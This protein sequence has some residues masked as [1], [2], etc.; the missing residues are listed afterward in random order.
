MTSDRASLAIAITFLMV[1][2]PLAAAGVSSWSGPSVV[3]SDG[4]PT[5]VDGFSVPSNSTIM[6]GWIHVSN[7][8]LS[9]SSDSGIVWDEDDFPSGNLA[10]MEI[11]DDG[12]MI[13]KDDGSRSNVSSFDVG[14]IEVTLNSDYTYSPGWR[15]VFVK[16]PGTNLSSC[17]GSDGTF[18]SHGVDDDFDQTLDEDEIE[19]TMYFC[20]TFANQDVVTY[21]SIDDPGENYA[22]GNLSA[23]GGGGSGF[24]GSYTISS[25]IQSITINSGGSNYD[26]SDQ[27]TIQCQ[28]DGIGAE[29]SIGSVNGTGAIQ[30]ITIDESGSGYQSNDFIA[31]SVANGSGASLSANLFSTGI[32]HSTTIS[33][34]GSNYTSAPSIVISDSGGSSGSISATLGDYYDY[35]VDTSTE[36]PGENCDRGGFKIESG[37]DIN[38]NRNL[39][40]TEI[41]Q[42]SFICH[43][44]KL[45]QAT[46]F[47]D[48]GGTVYADEQTLSHGVVPSEA[49]QGIV[50]A[51]TLP[52]HPVPAGTFGHLLIPEMDVPEGD[53]ISSY[54]LT[55]DHWYHLDS[56]STGE[57]DGTWVEYRLKTDGNWENWTYMEP[58]GGYPSTISPEAPTPNG[59]NSSPVPV[60]AS[61]SHSGWVS[62]N[63]SLSNL[64]GI[65]ESQKIQFRFLIW[66]HPNASVERPGWFIDNI[67]VTNYGLDMDIW[68]HGCYTTT[69]NSCTYSANAYGVLERNIDLS[70]TN[71]TSRIEMNLEWDLEGAAN[72]NA[73]VEISLNGNTWAD[74]SSSTSSTSSDCS[75]RTGPIPG[76][77]YIADNG[78]TYY[79]STLRDFRKVS[80][81]IPTG[82]QDKA[83]VYL[84]I[85]V[86]TSANTNFGGNSPS[87]SM[88]GIGVDYIRVLD[89]SDAILFVDDFNSSNT[90]S[91]YG[92]S[93]SPDDWAYR[94]ITMGDQSDSMGFEDSTASAPTVTDAEGWSRSQSG[95]CSSDRCKFTLNKVSSSSGPPDVSSFPYAYGVGFS[96]VYENGINE[97]RLISPTYE[98]PLNG[99]SFLTF[100]HW[101]CSEAGYDGGAVFIKVNGG[102]WQHF[103]PG[104]Y[105]STAYPSLSHNLAGQAI[106]GMDHCTGSSWTGWSST[107]G[108]TNLEANLNPYKGD[109]VKF[110]FAFASDTSLQYAGWFIDN[111]GV[112][113]SNFG[114]PGHWTSPAFSMDQDKRFNHGFVDIEGNLHEDGWLTGSILE[115][116]TGD[117][118]PGFSNISFP[119]SLAGIDADRYP[120][121]RLKVHAG[122]DDPEQS[123]SIERIHIGGKRI[124]N[125]DSG[126]NGWDFS[127]GVEVVNGLLNATAVTGTITSD[128]VF[129]TRPIK[130]VTIQGNLSSSVSVTVYDVWGNSL[131]TKSKGGTIHFPSQ[132]IGYSLS[133][134]LPTNGWIDVIRV[135]PTFSNPSLGSSIDVLDDGTDEW[136]FPISDSS[137]S[138]FG[139]LGWQ[140]LITSSGTSSR[141]ESLILDGSNPQSVTILVPESAAV[142]SGVISITP[143]AGGFSAPVSVSVAGSSVSG[144]SGSNPFT[145]P[146]SIAQV[147]AIGQLS[148]SLTDSGSGRHWVEVPLSI[149]SS[150]PQTVHISSIGIGYLF[151]ENVSG[152]GPSIANYLDSIPPQE[153]SEESEIPVSVTSEYGSIAI[154]GSVIF[155]YMFVNRDFSVPKTL[156]PDGDP[157][158]IVTRHNHLFNNSDISDIT[159]IGTA[160]DGNVI[161]FKVENSDDGAWGAGPQPVTFSQTSGRSLSP[162]SLSTSFVTEEIN[163]D[164]KNDLAVHWI[165]TVDW[166][167]ND[168]DNI[169]WVAAANDESGETIWPAT[170]QSGFGANAVE[171]DLQID[172]FEIKD[173]NGR[174]ISNTY[175]TL[176]YP[177]HILDGGDL[178]VSGTVRF[179]DSEGVRPSPSDFSVGLDLS[180]TVIELQ[181]DEGGS[182]HGTVPAPSGVSQ[183]TLTPVMTRVGPTSSTTGA[184][185]ATGTTTIVEILVDQNPPVAGPIEVQTPVGL[186]SVDGMV[187]PPTSS[188]SP[189]V[190]IS[191]GEA[192][193]ESLT[194]RYWREGIDDSDADGIADEEEYQAQTSQLSQGLTGEQQV[195]FMGIDVSDLNNEMIHLYLE[196]TDW[197]GL[198]YQEGGTGGSPGSTNSWASVVIADDVMVE[199]AGVGLGTGSEGATFSLDRQTQDSIDYFLIPGVEHTFRVR[200]DEPNGFRTI[201][202]ISVFLCGYSSDFGVIHYDPFSGSA[203]SPEGSMV[204]PLSTSTEQITESVT[205][206]SVRFSISWDMPFTEDD[207]PCKPRVLVEDGL[208]QIESQV[209]SSL[210]WSLDNRI[211]A[212]PK[213][214]ED[215]TEPIVPSL[216]LELFLGQ[217]DT[218]RLSG[219]IYHEGSGARMVGAEEGLTVQLSLSY[220]SGTYEST[221]GV[222]QDGNFSVEMTLPNFQPLTPTTLITTS[223]LNT[224]GQSYSVEYSEAKATV[225]TK[226]PSV[227]FDVNEYPDSSLTIIETNSMDEVTV[228]LTILE[229]I[230]M[231]YG[232]LQVSWQFLRNGEPVVGT[233]SSGEIPWISS[234]DGKHV[235]QGELDFT[236]ELQ[237]NILDGD[238]VAFWVS[239]TDKAGNTVSG[240]GGPETPRWTSLRIVE[241]EG[242]YTREVV[243]PTRNPIVGETIKVITYWENPGKNPGT[244]SVG[245]YE[246]KVDGTWVPSISTLLDGPVELYLPPG[247]S[248]IKA[249]FEYQTWQEGQPLLIL[250]VDKDFNNSNYGNIEISDIEVTKATNSDNSGGVTLWVIGSLV[251][252][253]SLMGGAFYVLRRG[254]GGEDYFY[255]DYEEEGDEEHPGWLWDSESGEWVP[256]PDFQG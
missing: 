208:D 252:V 71:S 58:Q 113:I 78:Q 68:H 105:S 213:F 124:L 221:A 57:G 151:F 84:R 182:F 74:I 66:T 110:K 40:S 6:D 144:G 153:L 64:E 245:M 111:A 135:V 179:Q 194:L 172:S 72:D 198:S 2:A 39:E 147:S 103:D 59:A 195:Q 222:F 241:F 43:S 112:K 15:R 7:S 86:D 156:Y 210:S 231:S 161:G 54:H 154:D 200:L 48:L 93:S 223:I 106:F 246:Q 126:G 192:R 205:E 61:T 225:D 127:A 173:S 239:S 163:S 217:G 136:S 51:G 250:V 53:Y 170:S 152:L 190:T 38:K 242:Q 236:P 34:G 31:V 88:E 206:L 30:S 254:G 186:Q 251:V 224:P 42:T 189:Y 44:H 83:N 141:S 158:E 129:S 109:S 115:A 218:F 98:I 207:N 191:E 97:A 233:E 116:G 181:T 142:T 220:G 62:S 60:F 12:E 131:G 240:L 117:P 247:S 196:G 90:M 8:P 67:E 143:D 202:N 253:I 21:L 24:S 96:G 69:S 238:K 150:S 134:T 184:E 174:L 10:G 125:A 100:D 188:F 183:M 33:E 169:F 104:W 249:E 22:V 176:F 244:I 255:D 130:S 23:T 133:V 45:W 20:E 230:G 46:T 248:S 18:I 165:F 121:V 52:G 146:L 140:S 3:N 203:S 199:F 92:M 76:N 211:I 77:G 27:I 185:D 49:S 70:G 177:F 82:F 187:V 167:W 193:G 120:N 215:L 65:E 201:D 36:A 128:Y 28:C 162:L 138:G 85:V 164:G 145:T 234:K 171:N 1:A 56:T 81:D 75:Q 175:D 94:T 87:D 204:T 214:A 157:I 55:F 237:F 26:P 228:T 119:F 160:S 148:P 79:D 17:G 25:G 159:L 32:I 41:N 29:A 95:T 80:F 122:S 197:A 16:A 180:G 73:C 47:M 99:T 9:S 219:S 35:E 91:H 226:N 235:Y 139:H 178:N 11:T 108:M 89:Y 166:G 114:V 212:V 14:Q 102:A 229:E 155:D 132:E 37:L 5:V 4:E 216:G 50:S 137:G 168:V 19:E 149:S 209:L 63:F 101:S 118:I 123:P 256:D 107:S 13:L 227:L 232:P 243:E